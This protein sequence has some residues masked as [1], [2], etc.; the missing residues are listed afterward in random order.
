MSDG[1]IEV[2]NRSDI[3]LLADLL[4]RAQL[5]P[6]GPERAATFKAIKDFQRRLAAILVA[7]S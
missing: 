5:L 4:D 6:D 7:R 1:A 2:P 3:D